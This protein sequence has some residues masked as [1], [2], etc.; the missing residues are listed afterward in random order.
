M[1]SELFA[2]FIK[3]KRYIANLSER[4]IQS[5]ESHVF[6]R[7]MKYVGVMPTQANLT[8]FVIAM[9]E[10]GLS[11]TTCNITIRSFNSFLGWLHRNGHAPALRLQQLKAEKRIMKTFTDD[12]MRTLLAWRP[13]NTRNQIRLYAIMCVLTDTGM[14]IAE[15]LNLELADVDLDN[16]LIKVTGK[17]RKE[18]IVPMSI[19]L[20]N[21]LH[22]FITWQRVCGFQSQYLF[23]TSTGT[24]MSYQNGGATAEPTRNPNPAY[25]PKPTIKLMVD[26]RITAPKRNDSNA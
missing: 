8:Q 15:C 1:V 9:R 17:G 25:F 12:Q 2:Q 22:R 24:P 5:Y 6:K 10:D 14:R 19:E 13:D 11:P 16:L 20:R 3:E 7:W 23:C 21:V 26:A 4:T 18:R